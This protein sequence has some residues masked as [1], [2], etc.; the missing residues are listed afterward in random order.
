MG[1]WIN[2]VVFVMFYKVRICC[3]KSERTQRFY[4]T[5]R[6]GIIASNEDERL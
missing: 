5:G 2:V 6:S 3:G 4:F 1:N